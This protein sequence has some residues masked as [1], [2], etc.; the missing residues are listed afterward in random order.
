MHMDGPPVFAQVLCDVFALQSTFLETAAQ[1][2]VYVPLTYG[3]WK[4]KI[5]KILVHTAGVFSE[6][7]WKTLL[8]SVNIKIKRQYV[9]KIRTLMPC[10][11]IDPKLF[12]TVPNCSV[13]VQNVLD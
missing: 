7:T 9:R 13:T 5:D 11:S 6:P 3:L 8:T 12:W 4:M 2:H 1:F 10:P